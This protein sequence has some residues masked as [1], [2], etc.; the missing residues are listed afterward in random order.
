[1]EKNLPIYDIVLDENDPAHGVGMISLVDEPAIGV[2]WIKL[3][4]KDF[5]T[6]KADVEKKLLYGPFLIP[7]KLIYRFD[8]N[9]GE[10]YVRFKK[11][12][13]EKISD[14]FN[15][16]LNNRN[17][18][19]MHTDEMVD[20][21]VAQ[22]WLVEGDNDKSKNLKFD[23]PEGTWFGAVKIKDED[24]W[25]NKVK[26]D[27]V[28]GFSVEIL[29][30]LEL[31]LKNNK[32]NMSNKIKLA[33]ATLVDGTVV[34][35]DGELVV[36]T[37]VFLDEAMTQPAPDASHQVEGGLVVK[38]EGGVVTEIME[39]E[40]DLQNDEGVNKFL[41]AEEISSMI[42]NRFGEIMEEITRIKIMIE[43]S[44]DSN[45]FKS[46]IE[47]FRNEIEEKFKSIP[48]V[49]TIRK[50][51]D[52]ERKLQVKIDDKF[53]KTIEKIRSFSKK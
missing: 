1:M 30:S 34:Y 31:S 22:N 39:Q 25:K 12:D 52:T 29:A 8:D 4:K 21:F 9:I 46:Q 49:G 23:L 53:S 24:F 43:E 42:D 48:A 18:N 36:G 32:I 26:G 7:N 50:I 45:D 40:E 10:Y 20:A 19:F 6:F 16:D 3:A 14:K 37:S 2:N 13:I 17:I 38:T 5:M 51:D 33:S 41:T 11:E 47:E 28:K 35:W 44:K 27:E 15:Q